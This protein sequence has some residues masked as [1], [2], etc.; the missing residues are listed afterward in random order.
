MPNIE[1]TPDPAP[2]QAD[3]PLTK[4]S[5][6]LLQLSMSTPRPFPLGPNC[7]CLTLPERGALRRVGRIARQWRRRVRRRER[8][9]ARAPAQA[10]Q[11]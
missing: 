1:R 9:L 2:D 6:R 7:I 5:R 8:L 4:A 10:A 3:P 11:G